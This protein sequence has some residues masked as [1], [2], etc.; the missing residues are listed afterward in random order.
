MAVIR[1]A[2]ELPFSIIMRVEHTGEKGIPR[3]YKM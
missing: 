1:F 3:F 2:E